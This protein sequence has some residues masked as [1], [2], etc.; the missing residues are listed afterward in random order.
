MHSGQK[1]R[2]WSG[3][4]AALAVLAASTGCESVQEHCLTRKLWNHPAFEVR[5]VPAVNPALQLF[6]APQRGDVLVRYDELT[7]WK[8]DIRP[9]AYWLQENLPRV[10]SG[11]KPRFV[12]LAAADKL[13]P[14]PIA[15][16]NLAPARHAIIDARDGSFALHAPNAPPQYHSL[17]S[18][19]DTP[20][21]LQRLLLTPFAVAA[22]AVQV[23]LVLGTAGL[24]AIAYSGPGQI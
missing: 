17:P 18:Y 14:I 24:L 5:H 13:T 15:T 8:D 12:P 2:A 23:G 3:T 22:D 1:H 7:T 20:A 21:R 16:T 4:L 6:E 11:R 10:T 9:R 19:P